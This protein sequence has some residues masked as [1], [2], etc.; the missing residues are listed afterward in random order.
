M[1]SASTWP[2][3]AGQ[4]WKSDLRPLSAALPAF[5]LALALLAGVLVWRMAEGH[6]DMRLPGWWWGVDQG[7]GGI[8][9]DTSY[10]RGIPGLAGWLE[11]APP[12]LPLV[13]DLLAGAALVALLW[14]DVVPRSGRAW[15]WLMAGLFLL[16]PLFA[17]TVLAGNGEGVT[18]LGLYGVCR[19]ASRVRSRA[20][21]VGYLMLA[22]WP[23]VMFM[24]NVQAWPI[25]V[26][27]AVCL[28]P[29]IPSGLFRRAPL[30]YHL[31]VFLPVSFTVLAYLYTGWWWQGDPMA[32]LRMG[33]EGGDGLAGWWPLMVP[34][35]GPDIRWAGLIVAVGIIVE[36][37]WG[38]S[39]TRRV[40][41]SV[42]VAVACAGVFAWW[43]RYM[44][45]DNGLALFF[46]PAALVA[47]ESSP[48]RRGWIL[49]VLVAGILMALP[50]FCRMISG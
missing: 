21:I 19:A 6:P 26:A 1:E 48:H 46:A 36:A 8:P 15:A 14:R 29:C 17:C 20:D 38:Q 30:T 39:Q 33:H 47:G 50:A 35:I 7:M 12:W 25:I 31:A 3:S 32:L 23:V 34:G 40:A 22:A 28:F 13:P 37:A 41:W 2:S 43:S 49:G 10:L 42:S 24:A 18:L 27:L 4:P 11:R 45:A 16:Q 44:W 5:C 9:Q